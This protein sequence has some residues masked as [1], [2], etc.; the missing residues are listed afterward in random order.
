MAENRI[1]LS[2]PYCGRMWDART[3]AL[4]TRTGWVGFLYSSVDCHKSFCKV[5]T[6]EERYKNNKQAE[7]RNKT[8]PPK[9]TIITFDWDHVGMKN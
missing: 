1:Q 7:R 2:C 4:G 6:P 9:N 5:R 8:R 3:K